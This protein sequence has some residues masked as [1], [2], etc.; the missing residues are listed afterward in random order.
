MPDRVH[1]AHILVKTEQEA[2]MVLERL[3][4]GEKFANMAAEV[5]LCPSRKRGGDLGIFTRGKMVKEFEN[6]AFSL[7]KGETSPVVKTKFGY[8]IVKRLE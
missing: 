7:Q 1:C 5:S 8:H 6:A 3:K 4:K 2:K